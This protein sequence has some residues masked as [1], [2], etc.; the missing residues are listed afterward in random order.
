V[1]LCVKGPD[2]DDDYALESRIFVDVD[3]LLLS[4]RSGWHLL[5]KNSRSKM[6]ILQTVLNILAGPTKLKTC[7]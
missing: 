4:G 1:I 2:R 5:M 6:C 7:I 3:V